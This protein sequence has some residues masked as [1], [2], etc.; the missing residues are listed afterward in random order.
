VTYED[1]DG[2]SKTMA[3]IYKNQP[4]I[5]TVIYICLRINRF[6]KGKLL[7][8]KYLIFSLDETAGD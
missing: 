7:D 4:C 8:A 1:D 2:P 5:F 3:L 6:A